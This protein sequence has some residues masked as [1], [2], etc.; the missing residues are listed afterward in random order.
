MADEVQLAQDA[1]AFIH[2]N[3]SAAEDTIFGKVLRK[4]IPCNFIYEDD[5]VRIAL[6]L[7]FKVCMLIL[8]II[9]KK[10]VFIS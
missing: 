1:F 8:P 10:P 5:L 2:E 9:R 7:S 3:A 6:Y 4:E